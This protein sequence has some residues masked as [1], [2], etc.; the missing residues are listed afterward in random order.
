M[1]VQSQEI[2]ICILHLYAKKVK[3]FVYFYCTANVMIAGYYATSG[4]ACFSHR[5]KTA[6]WYFTGVI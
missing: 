2:V 5:T 4:N 3:C 1:N 6:R